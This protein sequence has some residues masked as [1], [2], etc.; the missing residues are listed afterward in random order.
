MIFRRF[1]PAV[2]VASMALTPL[3][4]LS[5]EQFEGHEGMRGRKMHHFE[6]MLNLTDQQ[7][8]QLATAHKAEA[9]RVKPYREQVEAARKQL[10]ADVMS[11]NFNEEKARA[12]LAQNAEARTEL[13][14]SHA[15]MQAALY[16]VL[17]PEQRG[18]L[19]ERRQKWEQRHSQRE[20]GQQEKPN[21]SH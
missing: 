11:G 21:T 19:D 9:E 2:V 3:L 13:E 18:K 7:K 20:Q 12:L 15:R 17:T 16:N 1:M 6:R 4:G 5:Q 10:H 14:L 8:Q